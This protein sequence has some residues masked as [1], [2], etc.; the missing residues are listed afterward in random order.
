MWVDGR[1]TAHITTLLPLPHL[2]PSPTLRD[3]ATDISNMVCQVSW[4]QNSRYVGAVAGRLILSN[5]ITC[6]ERVFHVFDTGNFKLLNFRNKPWLNFTL[7]P[8]QPVAG[9]EKETNFTQTVAEFV[10]FTTSFIGDY[11]AFQFYSDGYSLQ[12]VHGATHLVR[13]LDNNWPRFV[14]AC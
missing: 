7:A 11:A 14:D 6:R 9:R 12:G 1:S 3:E 5:P 13:C 10:K 2:T 8:Y 4:S